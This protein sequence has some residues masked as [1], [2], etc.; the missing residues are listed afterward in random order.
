MVTVLIAQ[1]GMTALM[2]AVGTFS[3]DYD[4][5][6]ARL[7]LEAGADKEARDTRVRDL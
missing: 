2:A 7:L 1:E 3:H 5:E 6:C 4:C